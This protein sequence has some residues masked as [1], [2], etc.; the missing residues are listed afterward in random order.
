MATK[1]YPIIGTKSSLLWDESTDA[2]VYISGEPQR[3]EDPRNY[4]KI[5]PTLFRSVDIRAN[6]IANLPWALMKGETEFETSDAYENKTGLVSNMNVMLYL[7]E[8]SLSLAGAAYWKRETNPVG[9]NKL[10]HLDPTSMVLNEKKARKGEI[11]WKR[12][13]PEP[14]V[15]T[16]E[17]IVYFWYPDP[18]VEIGPPNS[19]PVRSALNACGVLANL[20]EFAKNYFGRG[21]IKAML[22]AMSGASRTSAEEFETWWVKWVTGIQNAFRTK[23]INA[24]KVEP[25][26]VGEGIKELENVSLSQEKREEIALAL[27][28]PMS[29]LFSSAANYATAERDK[30]NWYE[31]KIVPEAKFIASILNEQLFDEHGLKMVFRHE[32]LDIFQEDEKERSMAL[33][34]LYNAEMP[35]DIALR[36]LGFDLTDEEWAR[37]KK[38][39]AEKEKRAEQ[40]AEQLAAGTI[41]EENGGGG[42]FHPNDPGEDPDPWTEEKSYLRGVNIDQV[43]KELKDWQI[44]CLSAI[45]RGDPASSVTFVPIVTP[46]E[47]YDRIVTRLDG[48][49]DGE[50][51]KGV[52]ASAFRE[53]PQEAEQPGAM[54]GIWQ[55]LKRANDLLAATSAT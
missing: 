36:V 34:Y 51:V 15:Y 49:E 50:T 45:K 20:D 43:R 18:Y 46:G 54:I 39:I 25:V 35:L 8:A 13:E 21:A 47:I 19:W 24:E 26:I 52:F 9:Y 4:Y 14:K 41:E 33:G 48:A 37:I 30:L 2:W 17:E 10:R 28:I 27:A 16:P 22:F 38:L 6:A 55:E 31:D 53:G 40:M 44:L 1:S 29:L 11:E 12:N 7:I 3:D 5:I 32:T 42:T 23:V